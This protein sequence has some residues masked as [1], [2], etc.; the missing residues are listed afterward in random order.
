M[1]AS[2]LSKI[3]PRKKTGSLVIWLKSKLAANHLLCAGQALFG[4]GAYGAFCSRYE[5]STAD[6][7]CFNCNAH[8]AEEPQGVA[9]ALA[10]IRPATAKARIRQSVRCVPDNTAAQT[11]SVRHSHHRRYLAMQKKTAAATQQVPQSQD[12]DM[13]N[14]PACQ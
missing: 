14:R 2:W 5:P 13:E 10:L 6:K 8:H 7:L 1:E 12:V 9:S 4:G 11:G 3:N